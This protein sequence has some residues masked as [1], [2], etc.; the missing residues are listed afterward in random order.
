MDARWKSFSI[1]GILIALAIAVAAAGASAQSDLSETTIPPSA[2]VAHSA[3]APAESTDTEV[4]P[5]E[6]PAPTHQAAA[7]KV[8]PS[9]PEPLRPSGMIPYTVRPGDSLGSIA[10]MFGVTTDAIRHENRIGSDDEL[11]AGEVLKVPNPFASQVRTL[12]SQLGAMSSQLRAAD[13]KSDSAQ[14]DVKSLQAQVQE[15]TADNKEL[16]ASQPLLT[17]WRATAAS[18]GVAL[19]LMFGVMALTLFEWWRMRRKFVALA[20]MTEALGHLDYKYK[21]MLAK[22]ELRLQQLYGRRRQGI[23]EGQ[24]RPKMPEEIEIERLNEEL[25]EILETHL[26]RLGARPR[27]S[28]RHKG[29]SEMLGGNDVSATAEAR[30]ARR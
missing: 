27:G 15:L 1:G 23:T 4:P 20:T 5:A 29:W 28:R 11:I 12:E 6:E 30:S 7:P 3:P 25:K 18:M 24:P 21:A 16:Q 19:L 9:A 14:E 17:W 26:E 10:R 8:P 13:R 2:P 22:A